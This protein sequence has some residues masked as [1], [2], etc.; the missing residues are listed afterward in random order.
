[1]RAEIG[2]CGFPDQFRCDVLDAFLDP[3]DPGR[4]IVEQR[5]TGEEIDDPVNQDL[6][7][8]EACAARIEACLTAVLAGSR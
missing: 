1:M 5:K 7:T 6:E 3:V 8:F 4:V 2:P